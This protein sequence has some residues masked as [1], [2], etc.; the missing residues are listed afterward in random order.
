MRFLPLIAATLVALALGCAAELDGPHAR[1]ARIEQQLLASCSCHPK[2]I[3][4]LALEQEIRSSILLGI[5][6]GL[7]DDAILWATLERHGRALLEAG[8]AD[9]AERARA[10]LVIAPLS[11][12]LA[13]VAFLLQLRPGS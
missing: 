1:A 2:K 7:D 5:E 8:I 9:I 12:L 11:L 13:A 6:R 4:G 10:V 3:E